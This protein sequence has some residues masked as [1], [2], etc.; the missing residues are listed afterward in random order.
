MLAKALLFVISSQV[1]LPPY[2]HSGPFC[3][4]ASWP[5][6][7]AQFKNLD[8]PPPSPILQCLTLSDTSEM[9]LPSGC[10]PWS[11]IS[12]KNQSF[13]SLYYEGTKEMIIFLFH[14]ICTSAFICAILK[15]VLL[16]PGLQTTLVRNKFQ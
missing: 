6:T 13:L 14:D 5:F 16:I 10:F 9:P 15:L 3:A 4:P 7:L 8:P 11:L 2:L 12:A 1:C